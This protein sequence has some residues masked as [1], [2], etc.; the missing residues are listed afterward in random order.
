MA[1]EHGHL[2]I[3][4]GCQYEWDAP[5]PA[6]VNS[7]LLATLEGRA[8]VRVHATAIV[9]TITYAGEREEIVTEM[10]GFLERREASIEEDD[11]LGE[12]PMVALIITP[13]I[14]KGNRYNGWLESDV[15]D[16]INKRSG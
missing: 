6:E 3:S 2:L 5:V 4:W 14:P 13:V 10:G 11:A 15:W 8:F 9:A 7:G 1:S 12:R 16:R